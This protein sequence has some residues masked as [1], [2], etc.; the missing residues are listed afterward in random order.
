MKWILLLA[1]QTTW[2][3]MS[4]A[5]SPYQALSRTQLETLYAERLAEEKELASATFRN[6]V[7]NLGWQSSSHPDGNVTEW[8]RVDFEDESLI[9]LVVL[10]PVLWRDSLGVI[11]ADGFPL[12]FKVFI[13]KQGD[14]KG[15]EV[16]SLGLR[17]GLLP[18]NSPVMI[19]IPPTLGSWVRVEANQLSQGILDKR[20]R[21][22]VS[23]IIVFSGEENV[24]SGCTTAASSVGW[25]RIS[26]SINSN[27]LVDGFMPYLMDAAL[28]DGSTPY[29]TFFLA[30]DRVSF[31][32]DLG[33]VRRINRIHLH[34]ADQNANVPKIHH[35]DY[36]LPDH[37]VIS[38]ANQADFSDEVLLTEYK[39]QS[40]YNSGPILMRKFAAREC[41]FVRLTAM[42]GY[43]APEASKRWRCMGFAEVEIF[44]NSRNVAA[45]VL[46]NVD[47]P[48]VTK[49][50]Q[51]R[52]LTDGQNHFGPILT[53]REWM[54]QLARRHDLAI[55]LS[56]VRTEIDRRSVIQN[57]NFRWALG[58][59]A[60]MIA[61]SIA[62]LVWARINQVR[63][64]NHLKR[65]FA[66]DL[67]D[68]LGA[69]LH[70]IGLLSDLAQD[71]AESPA[72]LK[73][74]LTE[75]RSVTKDASASLRYMSRTEKEDAPYSDLMRLMKQA[76]ER[77]AVGLDHQLE[78][79]GTE[80][81][82][83]LRPQTR[84]DLLAFYKECI[85][86]IS[87]H[88]SATKLMTTLQVSPQEL[89]LTVADDGQGL[90][91]ATDRDIP[92]SLLRRAK[93]L[94]AQVRVDTA[95]T[96]GTSVHLVLRRSQWTGWRR[97]FH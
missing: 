3:V 64:A 84:A 68:G 8:A 79:N 37:L 63:Q 60:G 89:R 16:A 6:G 83:S 41:R 55:E 70:S 78:A 92:A 93:L 57:R 7:G 62:I 97:W 44:E 81:L 49:D 85:V 61:V 66:A 50:G 88:A 51:L 90:P 80:H 29:V 2:L 47:G 20:Y 77:I 94:G 56:Q 32:F 73:S 82:E 5:T 18:R 27:T 74:M 65:R 96:E 75:I 86:N 71:A 21:C 54:S 24:A 69:D 39:K 33:T 12:E 76:V 53:L 72:M 46:P 23:E 67:H 95:P 31:T 87:R 40:I 13:G 14:L 25:T 38:G 26:Q 11:Q 59:I 52:T 91:T 22:Q 17:D 42:Q 4:H 48:A 45:N 10:T 43:Q 35:A 30:K 36:A 34:S 19:P 9:D 28:G 1:L 15:K 58:I